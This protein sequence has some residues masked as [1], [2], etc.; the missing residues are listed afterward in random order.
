VKKI[1]KKI[2][3]KDKINEKRI[4]TQATCAACGYRTNVKLVLLSLGRALHMRKNYPAKLRIDIGVKHR[5]TYSPT[6]QIFLTP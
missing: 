5:G 1:K 3:N 4:K 2:K 6:S